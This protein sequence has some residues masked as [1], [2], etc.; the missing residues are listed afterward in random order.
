MTSAL[1]T[2]TDGIVAGIWHGPGSVRIRP[3]VAHRTPGC[4]CCATRLDVIDGLLRAVRRSVRPDRILLTV[5]TDDDL[6]TVAFTVLSDNDLARH[7]YL[8]GI[9]VAIDAV[10]ASTRVATGAPV[11]APGAMA[12]LAMAD[13][14]LLDRSSDLTRAGAVQLRHHLHRAHPLCTVLTDL[15]AIRSS[16]AVVELNAWRG[17]PAIDPGLRAGRMPSGDPETLV[18]RQAAPL[19]P[20]AVEAWISAVL[21]ECGP[22]LLRLQGVI[23][24]ESRPT[25]LHCH[26]V[27]SFATFSQET[28]PS[29]ASAESVVVLVGSD[30][31]VGALAAGFAATRVQ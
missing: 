11:A 6:A 17:P 15:T 5:D 24:I 9:V 21:N 31:D 27:R 19:H 2:E 3:D 26:G 7:V 29:K 10:A 4:P 25:R 8:D 14:I 22:R 23:A 20:H 28:A 13:V 18:L 16:R 30:L 1:A 12:D